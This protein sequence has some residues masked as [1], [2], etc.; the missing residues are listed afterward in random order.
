MD[1]ACYILKEYINYHEENI[2][3]YGENTVVLMQVGGFYEIYAV[4]NESI[5][6]GADIYKLAD[7]L[8][9]Q[10]ARRN[11]S[12]QEISCE[13]FLMAGW[14]TFA[15][16]KFQ[17]ILLNHNYTIVIVNQITEPPNPER[18]ITDIISPGTVIDNYNNSDTNYLVSVYINVY[19]QQ[20]NR[21]IYVVGLSA[22]D[23]STGQN[24]IH[25]IQ[26]S[27]G[28]ENL[29]RDE[30]FRLIHYYSPKETIFHMDDEIKL[31]KNDI[32]NQFEINEV[33]IH[34]QL[35]T[36][37]QFKKPSF[38][39]DFLKKIFD[40]GYLGA[41]EYLGLDCIETTLSYIYMIQFIH[42]HKLENL[43]SLPNPIIKVSGN[44]LVLSHNCIYQLYLIPNKEHESEKYNSL[45]SILNKCDTAIGRR[46]C[47]SRLLYPILDTKILQKRYDTIGMFR[48]DDLYDRM[49][50]NLKKILDVEKLHRK[51]GLSLLTPYEFYSLHT[52]YIYLKKN[53]QILNESLPSLIP[54][55]KDVLCDLDTY[56]DKYENIFE[57]NELEKYSLTNMSTSVFKRDV[58]P[59]IDRLQD[60]ITQH[61]DTIDLICS[62]LGKY[63]DHKKTGSIK[64]DHNEKYGF[65]LYVTETRS[66]TFKKSVNNL[67]Q[68][69]IQIG[70]MTLDLETVKFVKRGATIHVE[71]DYL[72][73][74][75]NSLS[76]DQLKIQSM[77]KSLY[78][79]KIKGMYNTKLFEEIVRIV[80]FIDLNSCLAKISVENVYSKPEIIVSDKSMMIAKDI[81]HPIVE[82]IQD[83]I[84]YIPNDV[85]LSENGI[86]LFGTNACGKS[87][88]MK[89]IGLTLIMAQAGFYVPCSELKYSPYTQL[90]TR[91]LN[92]DNIFKRQSSFA[93]EMS[94]LRGI[95]KRAD[96][97]SLVLGDEVCS[98][99]E[100]TSA[101]SIVSAGLKTLSDLKCSFIFTSHLHQLMDIQIIKGIQSLRIYH[102][103]IEY[104]TEKELL[105]YKRKLEKGSGPAIYGLEVCKALDLGN[106]FISLAR[107]I[108]MEIT[109]T[110]ETL[111]NDKKSNYN[112][113]ILMDICQIC[114][115]KS[116]HAHHIKEQN[117]A[118]SNGIIDHHHK[119]ISH[120]LVPL[121]ELCHHKVH[122]ENLRIYGYIQTNEGIKLNYEYI[123]VTN[124]HNSKK[125]FNKKD[126]DTIL[127][128]KDDI[129]EKKM[130]KSNLLKKLELEHHI[131]ISG[132]TLNKVLKGE[133]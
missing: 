33:T 115:E 1:N 34:L 117:E 91:I 49:K 53:I 46:L 10:V 47:K 4:I 65:Y 13:N 29:W 5:S 77:N 123:D 125:K 69:T 58:Y 73:N 51:M 66:K 41:T 88:L 44:N 120:N 76:S 15:L 20:N 109:N 42:E 74:I 131:Q 52:S 107:K 48:K 14:N 87:T 132:S 105:I 64:K 84:E 93:V 104:D 38:Q 89:S 127:G 95:L 71:F 100:T 101:L 9:I 90:F 119:N 72:N 40:P 56:M 103:K 112:T 82:R 57:L 94:E 43:I 126:L 96:K 121:C 83:E 54:E 25:K 16:P 116:E 124:E 62:K 133:Y 11:K 6:M 113:D 68:K 99:T 8:G 80:G 110:S 28:D 26:S 108:Q 118:D 7:I 129:E 37:S 98:G 3:K 27:L 22:I 36:D 2:I 75:S 70:S 45:L 21:K 24:T 78:L 130:K 23:V 55:N 79:D 67:T 19:P 81:R 17:K 18:G 97:N 85:S 60:K 61:R 86:L 111:V 106:D 59:E 35:Y 50:P 30:L 114:K 102:L 32:C 63:I 31:T 12:I 128:Y 39:N 92:N 122:N